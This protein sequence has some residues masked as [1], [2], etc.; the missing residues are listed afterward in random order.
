A[1]K[2]QD[3]KIQELTKRVSAL[4]QKPVQHHYELR[5]EGLRTWRFDPGTGDSCIKLTSKADWKEADTIRQGCEY[6]DYVKA[7]LDQG[8]DYRSRIADAEYI[9]VGKSKPVK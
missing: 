6:Q 7:P 4:E 5:S 3:E 8:E 9:Y 2:A 1:E